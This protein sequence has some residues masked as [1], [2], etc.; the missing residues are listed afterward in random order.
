MEASHLA[1]VVDGLGRLEFGERLLEAL[2]ETVAVDHIAV[3]RFE[4]GSGARLLASATRPG[5]QVGGAVQAAYLSHFHRF[6]PNR[7]ALA[8]AVGRPLLRRLR[9]NDVDDA[10]YRHH[11]FDRPALID[12]LSVLAAD[13]PAAYSL[14]LYRLAS[15][16][17]FHDAEVAAVAGLGG[18]LSALV[19]KQGELVGD[20]QGAVG[21]GRRRAQAASRLAA[22]GAGLSGRE[23]AVGAAIVAGLTSEAIALDLGIALNSVLT[24]RKRLYA[25]LA[26]A[27]QSDL[28]ALC[29][30]GR[31][32]IM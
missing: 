32:T 4:R 31:P 11:C 19:R 30:G 2:A 3:I 26:I 23:V 22:L 13:G 29:A 18:L 1:H 9:R 7:Q 21:P 16:G 12:R 5:R 8:G 15:S 25:K 28:F 24:Y 27:S 17:G 10:A 14:N 6:D 20:R